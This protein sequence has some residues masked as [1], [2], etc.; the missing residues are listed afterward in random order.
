MFLESTILTIS[1][2]CLTRLVSGQGSRWDASHFHFCG[3]R[4]PFVVDRSMHL[5][6]FYLP[7]GPRTHT[8]NQPNSQ[9]TGQ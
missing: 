9:L 6:C 8:R 1:L 5:I 7:S 2:F 4:Q 3:N